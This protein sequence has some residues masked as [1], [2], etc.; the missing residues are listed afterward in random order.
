MSNQSTLITD[1]LN[2]VLIE[3]LDEKS[4]P[5]YKEFRILNREHRKTIDALVKEDLLRVHGYNETEKVA[6]TLDGLALLKNTTAKEVLSSMSELVPILQKLY[7]STKGRY[8]VKIEEIASHSKKSIEQVGLNLFFLTQLNFWSSMSSDADGFP[9]QIHLKEE[10]LDISSIHDE[11][12]QR[13]K[14]KKN[15]NKSKSRSEKLDRSSHSAKKSTI[16]FK[17]AFATYSAI[18]IIGEGGSGKVFKAT[19]DFNHSVAVKVLDPSKATKEKLKRFKNEYTFCSRNRHRNIVTVIDYGVGSD[20]S[21]F[22][23]MPLYKSSLRN[24][25]AKISVTDVFSLF[26]KILDGVEAAHLQGVIH[27]DL[28]PENIL[29]NDSIADLAIADFGI[30]SFEEEEVY[31]AVLTKDGTRLA[32]F[33]YAAPEQRNRGQLIDKRADI[34]ALGLILNELFTKQIPLGLNYTTIASIAPEFSHLDELVE[35]MLQQNPIGRYESI[36]DIK[37]DLIVKSGE[38]VILQKI[39]ALKET[40][41]PTTTLDDSILENPIQVVGGDWENKVLKIFLSREPNKDWLWA[42]RNM[43]SHTSVL[44]KGPAQFTFNGA[45]ATISAETNEAQRI[46]NYFKDW[47]PTVAKIYENKMKTD[48][49]KQ[50]KQLRDELTAKLKTEEERM[51]LKKNL[52]F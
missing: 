25:M 37:K 30:A 4:F 39:S 34:Y 19:D 38:R 16:Q 7:I 35:K 52:K 47:L 12:R 51:K 11:I 23:V 6:L 46:V 50:E 1:L 36:E 27:R 24:Y 26:C 18:E 9:T 33:Q 45:T 5:S 22:F 44:G 3:T 17:T 49:Q 13:G 32:N 41:I 28:K 48:I 42:F 40:V 29:V 14:L 43:G 21:P 15:L 31:T 10:I 20:G 2:Q 8:P